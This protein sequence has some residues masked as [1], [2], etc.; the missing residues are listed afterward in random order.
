MA[1]KPEARGRINAIYLTIIFV[2]GATGSIIAT[3]CYHY[4]G[5][6]AAMLA[7]AALGI[8]NLGFFLTEPKV[9]VKQSGA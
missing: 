6:Q 1:Q 9:R 5:W 8:I 2:V 7:A 4:G 3:A